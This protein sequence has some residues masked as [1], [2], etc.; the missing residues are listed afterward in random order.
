VRREVFVEPSE[1]GDL[2]TQPVPFWA[3]QFLINPDGF[4]VEL[5]GQKAVP[6]E[7]HGIILLDFDFCRGCTYTDKCA[8]HFSRLA[9]AVLCLLC[10]SSSL[11][12]GKG[13]T[14]LPQPTT[15]AMSHHDPLLCPLP[16]SVVA[17]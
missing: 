9:R 4:L 17:D 10:F 14:E 7:Y 11:E 5:H 6:L 12:G 3:F 1:A 8:G 13:T 15:M 16:K 2:T